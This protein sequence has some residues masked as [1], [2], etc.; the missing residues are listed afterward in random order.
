MTTVYAQKGNQP[1]PRIQKPRI[2]D[3]VR[4]N[5]YPDNWFK[6]TINGNL[7][8]GDSIS[9][10]PHNVISV[11]LLPEDL[12]TIA[13]MAKDNADPDTGMEYD[14]TRIGDEGFIRKGS[15]GT[16]K[17]AHDDARPSTPGKRNR[18]KL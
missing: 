3:T 13:V 6:L 7:M 18:G 1:S 14:N 15:D 5:V 9:F 17:K 12:M 2:T 4:A 10:I 11:D 8:A 16:V